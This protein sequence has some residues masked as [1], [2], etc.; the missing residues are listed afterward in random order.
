MCNESVSLSTVFN[1]ALT[2]VNVNVDRVRGTSQGQ[3]KKTSTKGILKTTPRP[4]VVLFIRGRSVGTTRPGRE[5]GRISI[6][7]IQGYNITSVTA[8]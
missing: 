7:I 2:M 3:K 6:Q 4:V 1:S 8:V 5:A